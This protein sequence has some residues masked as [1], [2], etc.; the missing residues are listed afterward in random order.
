MTADRVTDGPTDSPT[1][2]VTGPTQDLWVEHL[3]AIITEWSN[4]RR[5]GGRRHLEACR[6]LHEAARLIG[7]HADPGRM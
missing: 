5:L 3:H 1:G 4:S 2:P 7:Q 6:S